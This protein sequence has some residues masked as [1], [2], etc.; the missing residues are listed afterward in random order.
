MSIYRYSPVVESGPNGRTI[1][2]RLIGGGLE[3]C[4]IDGYT[5][6]SIPLDGDPMPEQPHEITLEEVQISSELRDRIL[7]ESRACQLISQAII[8]RIHDKYSIDDEMYFAR[9]GVGAATGIYTPSTSELQEMVTYGQ[10]VESVREWGR[11][12]RAAL[13]L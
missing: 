1:S 8:D 6:V 7:S 13:G 10:H 5:Y 12:Q 4:H 3:L 11:Q 9:I 2:A